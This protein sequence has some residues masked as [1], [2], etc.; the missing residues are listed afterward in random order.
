MT[1]Y[2]VRVEMIVSIAA[3]LTLGRSTC[4]LQSPIPGAWLL[5]LHSLGVTLIVPEALDQWDVAGAFTGGCS[6][7]M[8]L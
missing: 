2:I 3:P 8:G 5:P 1:N 6:R 4:L 7:D